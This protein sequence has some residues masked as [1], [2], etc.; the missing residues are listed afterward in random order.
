MEEAIKS[1]IID[2]LN[3]R[4]YWG[5]RLINFDD[6]FSWFRSK[7]SKKEIESICDGLFNEGILWKKRGIRKCF[8]YSLNPKNKREI[9]SKLEKIYQEL[10]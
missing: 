6:V 4:S 1:T 5:R 2:K 10:I 8:R 7:A 3:R 9:E